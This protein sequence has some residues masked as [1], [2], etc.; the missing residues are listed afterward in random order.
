M[1]NVTYDPIAVSKA[2]RDRW[3]ARHNARRP[4]TEA[5]RIELVAFWISGGPDPDGPMGFRG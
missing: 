1:E 5:E 2:W 3:L 4:L